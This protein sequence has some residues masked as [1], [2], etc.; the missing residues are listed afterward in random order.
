MVGGQ[1]PVSA[2]CVVL[3]KSGER[4]KKSVL[5]RAG[6]RV[7]TNCGEGKGWS[8]GGGQPGSL[9]VRSPETRVCQGDPGFSGSDTAL[10][11]HWWPWR[12]PGQGQEWRL[13]GVS[14]HGLTGPVPPGRG[15]GRAPQ[16]QP[17]LLPQ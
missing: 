13:D 2:I 15:A 5:S 1:Q 6:W 17:G 16:R 4:I 10:R 3:L 7:D 8:E 14:G 9:G 12:E 11:G